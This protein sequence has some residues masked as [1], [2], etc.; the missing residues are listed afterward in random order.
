[1]HIHYAVL[2]IHGIVYVYVKPCNF[3]VIHQKLAQRLHPQI[4]CGIH[5]KVH[6]V[7]HSN[8]SL[9]LW[10]LRATLFWPEPL[11]GFKKTGPPGNQALKLIFCP[12][13]LSRAIACTSRVN[14]IEIKFCAKQCFHETSPS[15]IVSFGPLIMP[16]QVNRSSSFKGLACIP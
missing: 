15:H 9:S 7:K 12:C 13:N 8:V 10:K 16:S 5:S 2:H 11:K 3:D 1:V 6:C 14:Q 4:S